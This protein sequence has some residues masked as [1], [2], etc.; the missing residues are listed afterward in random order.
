MARIRTIKPEFWESPDTAKASPLARLLYIA[1]WNWADDYGVGKWTERELLGFAFPNDHDVTAADFPSLVKEVADAFS[2]QFYVNRG[3]RYYRIPA[4]DEHQRTERRAKCK[5]PLPDDPDSAPDQAICSAAERVGSSAAIVGSSVAGKG[6]G[7][8]GK[9]NRGI[10]EV[11][12]FRDDANFLCLLLADLIEGNGSKRPSINKQW[13]DAARLLL[14]KDGREL[15]KAAR[16]I[17]WCQADEFWRANILSM[18]KFR[19]KYDQLRLA[20]EAQRA[21]RKPTQSERTRE[22]V[23]MGRQLQAELDALGGFELKGIA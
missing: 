18:P 17:Q 15:D 21:A 23:E 6:T 14:D 10:G 19:E 13:H 5:H 2:T 11:L 3:R 1:M 12:A 16:L 8:Q 4:W 22:T 7:E 20:A 9:G